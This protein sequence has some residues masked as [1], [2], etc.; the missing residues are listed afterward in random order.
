MVAWCREVMKIQEYDT[1]ECIYIAG[2]GAGRMMM[3]WTYDIEGT[4][5]G[6]QDN[7]YLPQDSLS[8]AIVRD[9]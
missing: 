5:G 9:K 3:K 7:F 2:I 1:K 4:I 8:T 6:T